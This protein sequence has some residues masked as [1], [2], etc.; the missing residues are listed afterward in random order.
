MEQTSGLHQSFR[1]SCGPGGTTQIPGMARARWWM[2]TGATR[3]SPPKN[4]L[5]QKLIQNKTTWASSKITLEIRRGRHISDPMVFKPC[6]FWAHR[7]CSWSFSPEGFL[8]F[9]VRICG[10][11]VNEPPLGSTLEPEPEGKRS[12]KNLTIS[13]DGS[14]G[15]S[16]SQLPL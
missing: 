9:G 13:E 4:H 15:R 3:G 11:E 16:G 5:L 2:V 7:D 1:T 8:R 10:Q 12:R 14:F 6:G